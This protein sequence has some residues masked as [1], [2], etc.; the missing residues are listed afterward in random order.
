[1]MCSIS[2]IFHRNA[3]QSPP[4][5]EVTSTGC[6]GLDVFPEDVQHKVL[7]HLNPRDVATFEALNKPC[8]DAGRSYWAL[9]QSY[10]LPCH[11]PEGAGAA[12]RAACS[13]RR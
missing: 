12:K 13:W 6:I 2:K 9:P 1:M 7:G 11:L 8:R 4:Q 3:T 5:G 10:P